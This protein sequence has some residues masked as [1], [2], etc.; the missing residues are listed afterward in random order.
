VG[1]LP[2][3]IDARFWRGALWSGEAMDGIAATWTDTL[4]ASNVKWSY[5]AP[6][7]VVFHEAHV[8]NVE[9]G[10]HYITIDNQPG[11]QVGAVAMAGKVLPKAGPQRVTVNVKPNFTGD[12]F[13][14]DVV[15]MD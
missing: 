11:C 15:C 8:E 6:Q 13:F 3:E 2:L 1:G 12:T 4:G 10:T 14:V 5:F 7:Y 9:Y